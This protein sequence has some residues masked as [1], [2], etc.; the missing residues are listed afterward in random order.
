MSISTKNEQEATI[1]VIIAEFDKLCQAEYESKWAWQNNDFN[2]GVQWAQS[3]IHSLFG[4]KDSSKD[5]DDGK[6]GS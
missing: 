6:K 3:K 5:I 1:D 2:D 4:I